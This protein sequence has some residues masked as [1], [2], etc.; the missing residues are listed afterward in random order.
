MGALYVEG[1]EWCN[2]IDFRK[3]DRLRGQMMIEAVAEEGVAM[4]EAEW[5]LSG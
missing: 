5:I 4:A 3:M 1:R 2:L